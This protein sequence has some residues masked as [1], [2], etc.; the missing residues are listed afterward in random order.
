M[1]GC[2]I[3]LLGKPF[4]RWLPNPGFSLEPTSPDVDPDP[5]EGLFGLSVLKWL[6]C[7]SP[8]HRQP[9]N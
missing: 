9:W 4:G 3:C 5:G 6:C 2:S 1:T 7:Q 8:S